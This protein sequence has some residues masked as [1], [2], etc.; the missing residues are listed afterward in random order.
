MYYAVILIGL[1]LQSLLEIFL[2]LLLV[3]NQVDPEDQEHA[4]HDEQHRRECFGFEES[5]ETSALGRRSNRRTGRRRLR[6]C[7]R[8]RASRTA[9]RCFTHQLGEIH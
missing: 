9:R 8:G 2:F 5:E 6:A 7:P 4:D 1:R 3:E